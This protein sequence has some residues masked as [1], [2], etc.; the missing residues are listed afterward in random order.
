MAKKNKEENKSGNKSRYIKKTA[1]I[2]IDMV[3]A[4]IST[5]FKALGTVLLILLKQEKDCELFLKNSQ[6]F[7]FT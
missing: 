6:S 7:I 1:N 3:S 5:A 4:T 2:T